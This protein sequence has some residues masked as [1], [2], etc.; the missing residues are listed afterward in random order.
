MASQMI[1]R[2]IYGGEIHIV[3]NPNARGRQ[4]R[5]VVN[6]TQKPKGVTTILGDTLAKDLMDWAVSCCVD[7]LKE[8]L[9]VITEQDL[10]EA[11]NEYKYRRDSG[12]GTGSEAHKLVEEFLKGERP[13]GGEHSIEAINAYNAFVK[14]FAQELPEVLNVEEVIYSREHEYAGTYDCMLRI[15][16]KNYLC[17]LKTTNAS[18][19][20]PAG[21]YAEYFAQLGA[22]AAA[23]EE[24]RQHEIA[25]G[26]TQM[27]HIDDLLVI[28]AKKDGKLDI[29]AASDVGLSVEECGALFHSIVHIYKFLKG[30]TARLGGK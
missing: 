28:S 16:G 7:K 27:P 29:V 10:A 1:E 20:A 5:Y 14:W 30:T 17:D 9:P 24:Q 13:E 15:K 22:Y 3:H 23:H 25:H 26:G 2:D 4:P 18:R 19:K 6:G 11:A 21:V 12:A 8:K